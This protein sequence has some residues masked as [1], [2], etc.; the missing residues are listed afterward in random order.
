MPAATDESLAW[1]IAEK[2]FLGARVAL[3]QVAYSLALLR[4]ESMKQRR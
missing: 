4:P 3:P 1:K 2:L